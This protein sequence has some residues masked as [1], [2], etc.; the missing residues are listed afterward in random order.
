MT[1]VRDGDKITVPDCTGSGPV[2]GT[3]SDTKVITITGGGEAPT[4]II[5][6]SGGKFPASLKFDVQVGPGNGG[7]ERGTLRIVGSSGDDEIIIGRRGIALNSDDVVNVGST[8]TPDCA[9]SPGGIEEYEIDGAGGDDSLSAAGSHGD[10]LPDR[11][12]RHPRRRRRREHARLLQGRRA[13]RR[14]PVPGQR[15]RRQR[16][17]ELHP[18]PRLALQRRAHRR[19]RQLHRRRRRRRHRLRRGRRQRHRERPGRQDHHRGQRRQPDH[20]RL[21]NREHH[22]RRRRAQR[23]HDRTR[24]GPR[25]QR[26]KREQ[27]RSL[28]ARER[29]RP[30]PSESGTT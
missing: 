8:C 5:D 21:R 18:H 30:S 12:C 26:R 3:V 15:H 6:L 14:Q 22:Q 20:H 27:R 25:H 7:L 23:H 28:W 2:L 10:R 13:V 9:D 29:A 16:R 4:L 24:R 1:I 19:P 11:T 17:E